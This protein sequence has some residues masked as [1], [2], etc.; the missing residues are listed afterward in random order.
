ME[1]SS[2]AFLQNMQF[3]GWNLER[4]GSIALQEREQFFVQV[5][6]FGVLFCFVFAL[7]SFWSYVFVS[8]IMK[9]VKPE[10]PVC[11]SFHFHHGIRAELSLLQYELW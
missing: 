2:S 6:L 3:A 10:K 9:H 5:C 7:F 4:E 11:K 8:F 1:Y